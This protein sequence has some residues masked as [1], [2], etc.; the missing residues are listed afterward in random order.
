M[1]AKKLLKLFKTCGGIDKKKG[2]R[3]SCLPS[4][5]MEV[6]DT[7]QKDA[8]L[9]EERIARRK[10]LYHTALN[11]AGGK[12]ANA[13]PPETV[14]TLLAWLHERH[15]DNHKIRQDPSYQTMSLNVLLEHSGARSQKL[16]VEA[17]RLAELTNGTLRETKL[18]S[19]QKARAMARRH[20]GDNFRWLCGTVCASIVYS[21]VKDAYAALQLLLE[22]ESQGVSFRSH[23]PR[24]DFTVVEVQD[25]IHHPNSDDGEAYIL[26]RVSVDG[27]IT[28]I[29]LELEAVLTVTQQLE[30]VPN[31]YESLHEAQ[32]MLLVACMRGAGAL[33]TRIAR[34]YKLRGTALADQNGRSAMHYCCIHGLTATI[35]ILSSNGGD[36]WI[37]DMSG[38]LPVEIAL[39]NHHIDLLKVILRRMVHMPPASNADRRLRR[40]T[41]HAI[42]W[43]VDHMSGSQPPSDEVAPLLAYATPEVREIWIEI[44]NLLFAVLRKWDKEGKE[45]G[46]LHKSLKA[47]AGAG[48][49][50][51][52]KAL[53]M[54]GVQIW[55][56]EH[57]SDAETALDM[58]ITGRHRC[59]SACIKQF[60]GVERLSYGCNRPLLRPGLNQHLYQAALEEDL[61]YALAAMAAGASVNTAGTAGKTVLMTFAGT[62]SPTACKLLIDANA[63]VC[64]EDG[65]GCRA[66]QYALALG[67][68]VVHTFLLQLEGRPPR[69]R[70]P[71]LGS[72]YGEVVRHGCASAILRYVSEIPEEMRTEMINRTMDRGSAPTGLLI[73][74][75]LACKNSEVQIVHDP[76]G[77]VCRALL[78]SQADPSIADNRGET[79]LHVA[80]KHDHMA[81]YD[82]FYVALVK[83]H[84]DAKADEIVTTKKNQLGMTCIQIIEERERLDQTFRNAE[85]NESRKVLRMIFAF[86]GTFRCALQSLS[87]RDTFDAQNA[88][89]HSTRRRTMLDLIESQQFQQQNKKGK[90]HHHHHPK[91]P[92]PG[93]PHGSTP[94]KHHQTTPHHQTPPTPHA[95]HQ[96]PG[97]PKAQ[98]EKKPSSSTRLG[99]TQDFGAVK[100]EPA[101]ANDAGSSSPSGKTNEFRKVATD[102]NDTAQ[103]DQSENTN[104]SVSASEILRDLESVHH[105]AQAQESHHPAANHA[106]HH[107]HQQH[108][109][110]Q[111]SHQPHTANRSHPLHHQPSN[112]HHH[113]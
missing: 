43:W 84:G 46:Y 80:A 22:N 1:I 100:T 68:P 106:P 35:L 30:N 41:E 85:R 77:Q 48:Q 67:H 104:T 2:K 65:N 36:V 86:W 111:H 45:E 66:S 20:F 24:S 97:F 105:K 89:L 76:K 3:L 82:Q 109:Q 42:L 12:N 50:P 95:H 11:K 6:Y 7:E 70:F 18:Q 112:T 59:T 28:E 54:M 19:R 53:L 38:S 23:L 39:K 94:F 107:P 88:H 81:L 51:R 61:D 55:D 96:R 73:A 79:P 17:R 62:G 44:G 102:P 108:S 93:S 34:A 40:F 10:S 91:H 92:H 15:P 90:H 25:H 71:P 49:A 31:A 33:A 9:R 83:I 57:L 69:Q 5:L 37:G 98:T 75:E 72:F 110:H 63:D 87:W 8:Q 47:A 101:P 52:V 29:R 14:K 26:V 4:R 78:H 113:H 16:Q 64:A 99:K 13:G 74:T 32:E 21:T 103:L 27:L 60:L 58:A 56:A